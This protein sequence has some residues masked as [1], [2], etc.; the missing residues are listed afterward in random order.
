[1]N[2]TIKILLWV[3]G[4]V[5]ALLI[6]VS[7]V[8]GPVAKNYANRH[9]EDLTGRRVE[10]KHVG[11]NLLTGRVAVQ[12]LHVYEEDGTTQFA[13]FDTL[14][15]RIH[16]L[17]LPFRTVN[18][19]HIT[20]S[21]L[22]ANVLQDG[23]RFNFT[24][25][26]EHFSSDDT[27]EDKDT[28][29]SSWTLKFYNIRLSHARLRYNDLRSNK[30]ISLPDVNLRVPGFV[31]GGKEATEGGLNL[32]FDK[33]GRLNANAQYNADRSGYSVNLD[34]T[35]FSL[36]NIE[37]YVQDFISLE[38]IGGTLTAHVNASGKTT[39][40]LRSRIGATVT[41]A[42]VDLRD[43]NQQQ[44]AGLQELSVKV[45]NINLEA[46]SYDVAEV[47]LNGL[48]ANYEQFDGYTNISRLMKEKDTLDTQESTESPDEDDQESLE[49][50]KK[51]PLQLRIGRLL[52]E[53]TSLTYANHTLPDEFS[54]PITNLTVTATN[55][56]LSGDNNAQVRAT[57]PGGGMLAVRWQGNLDHW[58]QHQDIFLTVKGLDLKQLSPW[59]V[60]YTGQPVEDGIFG[61]TSRNSIVNSELN[62]QNI[63]DIY[64]PVVGKKRKDVK[65]EKQLPL[66]AALYVL[67]DK[68]NKILLDVPVT[69]NIDSPEFNYM[70]LVWKTLGNLI[71]KVATSPARALGNVL[72]L[73]GDDLEFIAVD[74]S[75]HSLTSEQYHILG[76]LASIAQSDSLIVLHLEQRM[77]EAA[78]D[79]IAR[80][81]EMRNEMVRRYLKEQ[82]VDENRLVIT[83]GDAVTGKEPTGYA[84]S[85]EMKFEE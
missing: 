37:G 42:D 69:G 2:K 34:L 85:S 68:D 7:L 53:N 11:L 26:L 71:V 9:G 73:N 76:Q 5:L 17:Q 83:T 62:G 59:T 56:S 64:N 84:V 8:A 20:L 28:T 25:L 65:A 35:D 6:I 32:S 33:G 15:I 39:E 16:L 58:K 67:K 30:G 45:N 3:V 80:H 46:N 49:P 66:K 18:L 79:T 72:G 22:R 1:M 31:L 36:K 23:D 60:A 52:V 13:G 44:L 43:D 19:R 50:T 82:G 21:G 63:I 70:K 41:L 54:F 51:S 55:L 24:S 38:E 77:P 40:L 81:Y 10:V 75:Q 4:I 29:P 27:T 57:L 14:D 47:H 12:G 74:P 61:L 48:T 78:N